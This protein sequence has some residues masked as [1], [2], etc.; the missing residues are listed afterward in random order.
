MFDLHDIFKDRPPDRSLFKKRLETLEPGS[1]EW[2]EVWRANPDLQP[3]MIEYAK[4]KYV[5]CDYRE[6]KVA[7]LI[8]YSKCDKKCYEKLSD[9]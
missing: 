6:Q 9:I 4:N 2:M 7:F 1:T 8:C 3:K 5:W